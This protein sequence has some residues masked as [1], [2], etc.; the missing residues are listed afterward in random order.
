MHGRSNAPSTH[1]W[2][3][4]LILVQS[5]ENQNSLSGTTIIRTRRAQNMRSKLRSLSSFN[6]NVKCYCSAHESAPKDWVELLG[7]CKWVCLRPRK[8]AKNS[9]RNGISFSFSIC[10]AGRKCEHVVIMHVVWFSRISR[11]KSR[12]NTSDPRSYC[13]KNG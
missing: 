13:A 11:L 4:I 12:F 1:G 5:T 9:R 7:S 10:W 2:L 3:V 8:L 6:S